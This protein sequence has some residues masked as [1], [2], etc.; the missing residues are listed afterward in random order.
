MVTGMRAIRFMLLLLASCST[1]DLHGD[2]AELRADIERMERDLPPEAPLWIADG[3]NAFAKHLDDFT[4]RVPDFI[5]NHIISKLSKGTDAE[6]SALAKSDFDYAA[7]L[8]EPDL[9]RGTFVHV[10]AIIGAIKSQPCDPASGVR[11][12]HAG[13]AWDNHRPVFFHLVDKPEVLTLHQDLIEFSGV[14]VKIL[15]YNTKDGT[16]IDAPFFLAKCA[17]KYY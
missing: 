16:V 5:Y 8:K 17:H 6:F 9:Q 12:V 15:R 3:D 11:E 2:M 4:S 14:F 13:L 7:C 10:R 1:G